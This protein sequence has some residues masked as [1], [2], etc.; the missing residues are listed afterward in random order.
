MTPAPFYTGKNLPKAENTEIFGMPAAVDIEPVLTYYAAHE[1]S[2]LTERFR[3][4]RHC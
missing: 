3:S 4:I 1:K 2:C